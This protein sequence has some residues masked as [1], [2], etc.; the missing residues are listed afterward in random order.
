MAEVPHIPFEEV[1][2][3]CICDGQDK[4]GKNLSFSKEKIYQTRYH[5]AACIYD[6]GYYL[7]M[8][9]PGRQNVTEDGK[10]RDV[11]GREVKYSC[12]EKGCRMKRKMGYKEFCIHMSNDHG[13][14]EEVLTKYDKANIREIAP[15]LKIERN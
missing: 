5:Y 3:C 9:P 10:P 14:L 11:L 7:D 12:Q 15:K 1:H 2:T 13:G 6:S 4:E 8:Y